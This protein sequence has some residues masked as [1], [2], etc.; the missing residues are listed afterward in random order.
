MVLAVAMVAMVAVTAAVA[1]AAVAAEAVAVVVTALAA[2]VVVM[3]AVTVVTVLATA[4]VAARARTR[5]T[6]AV[7]MADKAAVT[8]RQGTQMPSPH[9]S[10]VNM[11]KTLN[12]QA[13]L[14][15]A[16]HP[17]ASPQA[18][19]VAVSAAG[20]QPVVAAVA[21]DAPAA[22]VAGATGMVGRAVLARLR[23][24]DPRTSS[25]V[26]S[27][28]YCVGR[29]APEL[30]PTGAAASVPRLVFCQSDFKSPE[31]LNLPPVDDVFIALG[32]T[33]AVAGS[34]AAF[35]AVDFDAVLAVARAARAAGA[36]RLGV[37]SALG[38]DASSKVFY[39]R[40]KGEMEQAVCQLGFETV[41]FARPSLLDGEREHLGQPTRPGEQ[42]ALRLMRPFK[43]LIP[44]TW[45]PIR[46]D[47]V[48][49]ALI[50]AV[51]AGRP[52]VQVL[53]SADMQPR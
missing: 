1:H 11:T 26:Y 17:P 43:A 23:A 25:V 40:V 30:P 8:Q 46:A 35:R 3:A 53:S 7:K 37:V 47:D 51:Q 27:A 39:N 6:L 18:A 22:A 33:M 24:A 42:W 31:S 44:R 2:A 9:D 12:P 41:V 5:A 4:A 10:R 52:G 49:R 45:R 34:Q 28:V 36:R 38:A 20:A 50:A 13:T 15:P 48:A 19:T 16:S 32:T 14:L 29:R 21:A